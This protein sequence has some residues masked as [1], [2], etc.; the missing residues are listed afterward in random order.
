MW[1]KE[2]DRAKEYRILK[3]VVTVHSGPLALFWRE[4][5]RL[6]DILFV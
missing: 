5:R 3:A 2:A 6:L 1:V 4:T